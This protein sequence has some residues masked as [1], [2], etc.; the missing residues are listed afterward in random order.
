MAMWRQVSFRYVRT[1]T[2]VPIEEDRV[3]VNPREVKRNPLPQAARGA[4]Y[5]HGDHGDIV[6]T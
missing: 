4:S 6:F 3:A 2:R 1:A 5:E